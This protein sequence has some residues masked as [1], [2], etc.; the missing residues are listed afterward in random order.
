MQATELS[1]FG[2][3][4]NG[5]TKI[6]CVLLGWLKTASLWLSGLLILAVLP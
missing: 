3:L 2:K 1:L 5:L 6:L 4:D